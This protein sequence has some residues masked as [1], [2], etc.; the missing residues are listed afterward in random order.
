MAG[1]EETIELFGWCSACTCDVGYHIGSDTGECLYCGCIQLVPDIDAD[2]WDRI[3]GH[4]LPEM[5]PD[6]EVE[7]EI[8]VD[9]VRAEEAI[10]LSI[11]ND[12]PEKSYLIFMGR[13]SRSCK[14]C[15]ETKLYKEFGVHADQPSEL[16]GLCKDWLEQ[17]A[18]LEYLTDDERA[19]I[20][21]LEEDI[22]DAEE[23]YEE[24]WERQ[25]MIDQVLR[26]LDE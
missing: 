13:A 23:L 22:I 19:E 5:A 6:Q 25:H 1:E 24:V 26:E 18:V 15:G 17:E 8:F 16:C 12:V 2:L 3:K 21:A 14:Q 9:S 4:L 7:D 20:E 10:V 11:A